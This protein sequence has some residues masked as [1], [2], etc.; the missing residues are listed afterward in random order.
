MHLTEVN[1]D[2]SHNDRQIL[3]LIPPA[4]NGKIYFRFSK[5]GE[6]SLYED[7]LSF[8]PPLYNKYSIKVYVKF[9]NDVG[10]ELEN[11]EPF[12]IMFDTKA[13]YVDGNKGFSGNGTELSPCNSL[14]RAVDFAKKKNIKLIFIVSDF[15]NVFN[16][17]KIDSDIIIEPYNDGNIPEIEMDI[18]SVWRKSHMWF[19]VN[20]KGYLELRNINF[21]IKAGSYFSIVRNSKAKFYR[22]KFNYSGIDDFCFVKDDSSKVGINFLTLNVENNNPPKLNFM[23]SNNSYNILKNISIKADIK[24]GTIFNLEKNNYFSLEN[25]DSMINAKNSFTFAR[26]NKADGIF[27]GIIHKQNGEFNNSILFDIDSSSIFINES[28][29]I[30]DGVNSFQSKIIN[31]NNSKISSNKSLYWMNKSVSF[32]G[33]NLDNS[34]IDFDR[35]IINFENILEYGYNF[36]LTGSSLKMNSSVIR[37]INSSSAIN[38]VLDDSTFEGANNSVFNAN[39]EDKSFNFWVTD[40]ASITT[41]N[42]IYYFNKQDDNSAFIYFNNNNYDKLKPIWYSNIISTN[43]TLLENLEK[44]DAENILKDFNDKNINFTFTNEFDIDK[45]NFFMPKN[46]SPVLQGGLAEYTSP[47]PIPPK[48]FLGRNRNIQGF[49]IDIGAIQ[50]SGNF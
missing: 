36:R 38:F 41:V 47:I 44:K 30:A 29:F 31:A 9:V 6:W 7:P 5:T 16:P 19:D 13:I 3:K 33:F 37:N 45:N 14:E 20:G 32:I 12:E 21:N 42:S 4:P 34:S 50:V 10:N 43:V 39:I 26:L 11:K 35:S 8:Y 22:L 46:D 18:K 28:D 27:S 25:M 23:D 49:G 15:I 2:I 24:E 40:K 1:F 48:D 17:I